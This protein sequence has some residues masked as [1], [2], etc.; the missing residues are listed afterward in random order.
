MNK[1]MSTQRMEDSFFPIQ[2]DNGT[3]WSVSTLYVDFL[4]PFFSTQLL[5]HV[6]WFFLYILCTTSFSESDLLYSSESV[7]LYAKYPPAVTW[8]CNSHLIQP[9]Y[10]AWHLIFVYLDIFFYSTELRQLNECFTHPLIFYDVFLHFYFT[11]I[12]YYRQWFLFILF[13]CSLTPSSHLISCASTYNSYNKEFLKLKKQVYLFTTKIVKLSFIFIYIFFSSFI[14][15]NNETLL[16]HAIVLKQFL[17][18]SSLFT[19]LSRFSEKDESEKG[20]KKRKRKKR[21]ARF[22]VSVFWCELKILFRG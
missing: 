1:R 22:S 12:F 13:S 20:R 21:Q 3:E 17:L 9:F 4:C 5:H 7:E 19:C 15:L 10:S 8:T 11:H 2:P 16:A 6:A 14:S 18:L